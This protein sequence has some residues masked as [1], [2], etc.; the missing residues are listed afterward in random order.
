[1]RLH[2]IYFGG[3]ET[4][5]GI[6][7]CTFI[8]DPKG[9]FSWTKPIE[10]KCDLALVDS[11]SLESMKGP[12][13]CHLAHR[14]LCICHLSHHLLLLVRA[15]ILLAYIFPLADLY[16]LFW[17]PKYCRELSG[18]WILWFLSSFSNPLY[19]ITNENMNCTPVTEYKWCLYVNGLA[20]ISWGSTKLYTIVHCFVLCRVILAKLKLFLHAIVW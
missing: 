12:S 13:S 20:H 10:S 6:I 15:F 3:L 11:N 14:Y 19:V 2:Q 9:S 17:L 7:S 5:V 4:S 8:Y 1:M 18:R 16:K